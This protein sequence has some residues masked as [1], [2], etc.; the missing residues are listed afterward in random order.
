MLLGAWLTPT[1]L[2]LPKMGYPA[3]FGDCIKWCEGRNIIRLPGPHP[4]GFG[5][6]LTTEEFLYVLLCQI[7][8]LLS[9]TV[10]VSVGNLKTVSTRDPSLHVGAKN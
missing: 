5:V 1:N 6:C 4:L 2:P 9:Q 7:W 10:W 8:S 3:T